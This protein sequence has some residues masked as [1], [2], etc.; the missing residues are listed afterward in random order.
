MMTTTCPL[1]T[2]L[3]RNT[4]ENAQNATINYPPILC[5]YLLPP[6][7]LEE[8][9]NNLYQDIVLVLKMAQKAVYSVYELTDYDEIRKAIAKAPN[10]DVR[11]ILRTLVNACKRINGRPVYSAWEDLY[12]FRCYTDEPMSDIGFSHY[13]GGGYLLITSE[14]LFTEFKIP[15][16]WAVSLTAGSGETG[17]VYG[18][19]AEIKQMEGEWS[20]HLTPLFHKIPSY[21]K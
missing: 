12:V 10:K 13:G 5:E 15:E 21:L 11:R 7:R 4:K 2:L 20:I 16:D 19:R 14:K 1:L 17:R 6:R 9:L 8:Y 3:S 18:F